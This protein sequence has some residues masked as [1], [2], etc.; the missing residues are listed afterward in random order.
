MPQSKHRSPELVVLRVGHWLAL[1]CE[2][3]Q[4]LDARLGGSKLRQRAPHRDLRASVWCEGRSAR[5]EPY[6]QHSTGSASSQPSR[7]R[8]CLP[9]GVPPR[10]DHLACHVA[11]LRLREV[12]LKVQAVW[13]A[14]ARPHMVAAQRRHQAELLVAT[15]RL[16]HLHAGGKA[17]GQALS[18]TPCSSGVCA[19]I[20]HDACALQHGTPSHAPT[21]GWRDRAACFTAPRLP[22]SAACPAAAAAPTAAGRR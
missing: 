1:G 4:V 3:L 13:G 14:Q 7:N 16:K 17:W 6:T 10:L 21:R 8:P 5:H 2:V 9:S 12:Q 19:A 15:D 18:D 20:A 11:L 22:C